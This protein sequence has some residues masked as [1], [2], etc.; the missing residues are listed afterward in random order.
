MCLDR[1]ESPHTIITVCTPIGS[2]FPAHCTAAGKAI[3]AYLTNDEIQEVVRRNGL[4]QYTPFTITRIANL[5]E[6]LRLIRLR[7]Y[8]VD[9]QELERGLSGVAAP[10]LSVHKRVIGAVGIAGPTLRFRGKEL[11]E[12][13]S[14]VTEIGARL[15]MGFGRL[16]GNHAN[17][18]HANS[19]GDV[20]VSSGG[21]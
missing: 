20:R 17:A 9:H 4:R 6:N 7:G 12:K 5:R 21:E 16:E 14:L 3:L 13:V 1:L 2:M 18:T 8:A 11:A 15:A 19:T 10:V